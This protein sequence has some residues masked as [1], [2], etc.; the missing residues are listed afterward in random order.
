MKDSRPISLADIGETPF[1][2]FLTAL[3][4][5]LYAQYDFGERA[6]NLPR[7]NENSTKDI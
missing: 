1:I 3:V 6:M 4:S 5:S 2:P 7:R